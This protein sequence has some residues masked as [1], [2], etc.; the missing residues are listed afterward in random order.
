MTELRYTLLADGSTDQALLPLLTWLLRS[1]SVPYSIQPQWADL[2]RLAHPPK[3]LAERIHETLRLYPCDLLFVHRDAER[4]PHQTRVNE[5]R[6][7][8]NE[9]APMPSVPPV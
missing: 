9:V 6:Q 8:V 4:E 3:L 5:I 1:L 7:A 2:G